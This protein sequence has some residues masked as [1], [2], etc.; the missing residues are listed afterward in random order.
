[1]K[2]VFSTYQSIDVISKSQYE[3]GLD[4]FKF[5]NPKWSLALA[6][7]LTSLIDLSETIKNRIY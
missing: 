1:M 4:D 5:K 7:I 2:V 3:Y 6:T